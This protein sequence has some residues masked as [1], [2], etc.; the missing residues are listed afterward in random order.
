MGAMMGAGV[1]DWI[2]VWIFLGLV[3]VV[4]TGV[5]AVR[6]QGTG[7]KTGSVPVQ[8]AESPAARKARDALLQRYANG[9]ISREAYLQ[10]KVDL[11]D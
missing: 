11:E 9:E 4:T 3:M 10:G 2:L 8:P 5:V 7:R 6:V 1:G